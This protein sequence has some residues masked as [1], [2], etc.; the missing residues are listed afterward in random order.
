MALKNI[1]LKQNWPLTTFLN[2]H[3]DDIVNVNW[4][5]VLL[6]GGENIRK[7]FKCGLFFDADEGRYSL[8]AAS[9]RNEPH[10]IYCIQ[11][12]VLTLFQGYLYSCSFCLNLKVFK[13]LCELDQK[14]SYSFVP[15]INTDVNPVNLEM[16]LPRK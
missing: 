13:K 2:F 1:A 14:S 11:M 4:I 10:L 7:L 5:S 12:K 16:F 8:K 6:G 3:M 15:V 9:L